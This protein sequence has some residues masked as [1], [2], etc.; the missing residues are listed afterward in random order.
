MIPSDQP[1]LYALEV[2]AG[3]SDKMNISVGDHID[4]E[5]TK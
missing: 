5:I 3:I 4:F 1:A 2:K